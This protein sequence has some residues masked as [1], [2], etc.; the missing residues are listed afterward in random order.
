MKYNIFGSALVLATTVLPEF[1]QGAPTELH[2]NI[3]QAITAGGVSHGKNVA[4]RD[5]QFLNNPSTG[6]PYAIKFHGQGARPSTTTNFIVENGDPSHTICIWAEYG[7]GSI[8]D[9]ERPGSDKICLDPG[10]SLQ[11]GNIPEA[12]GDGF[13]G[14]LRGYTGCDG[15]GHNCHGGTEALGAVSKIEWT[16]EPQGRKGFVAINQSL[17]KFEFCIFVTAD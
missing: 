3:T 14:T 16:F 6:G 9:P 2:S 4:T 5:V 11:F 17:G 8:P 10:Q 15:Q 7:S 13:S 1:V 12:N